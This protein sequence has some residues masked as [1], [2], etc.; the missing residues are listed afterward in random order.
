MF[1][2][3]IFT[4]LFFTLNIFYATCEENSI[5]IWHAFDGDVNDAFAEIIQT[6]SQKEKIDVKLISKGNY[7]NTLDAFL[8][9]PTEPDVIHVFEMGTAV[10]QATKNFTPIRKVFAWNHEKVPNF[11][12]AMQSFYK[13]HAK[14]LQCLPFAA[15]T[16]IMFYNKTL[17][18]NLSIVAPE[19][20]EDFEEIAHILKEKGTLLT[21]AA[22][23]LSGHHMDQIG[24]IHNIPIAT[25][26]NGVDV[27]HAKLVAHPFF[28]THWAFLQNW[29][30][31]GLFS[32]KTGPEAEKAFANG[33]I[34][35]LSQGANRLAI[36]EKAVDGRFEI[37]IAHFPYWKSIGKPGKT[38]AG[39]AAFWV[40]KK[41][42]S[43]NKK[44][45]LTKLMSF[46]ADSKTQITWQKRT[47]HIPVVSI[48]VNTQLPK[49]AQIA[50]ESFSRSAP[51]AYNRGIMLPNF[52]KIRDL[53]VEEMTKVIK[54]DKENIS[55]SLQRI[56]D[57]G[58]ELLN[59]KH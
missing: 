19:T 3:V 31:R 13:G 12:P 1:I 33:E 21:L 52:P 20:F 47:G 34:T 44:I 50:Q 18:N 46:L 11:I 30:K 53:I 39:G 9:S 24:A 56:V 8:K 45:A 49:S 5:V 35:L 17:F 4:Y 22:G 41:K 27:P 2:K 26:G 38:I 37:G 16:V 40:A 55:E 6:F 32:L 7:N 28:R 29:H 15:S 10:M 43:A 42:Y 36:L 59:K 25:H 54:D 58:N 23:W 48:P 51:A 57:Q 14:E